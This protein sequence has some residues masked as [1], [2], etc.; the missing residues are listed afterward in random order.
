MTSERLAARHASSAP[1]SRA[2]DRREPN[3]AGSLVAQVAPIDCSH[4]CRRRRSM[5]LHACPA[6][7]RHPARNIEASPATIATIAA[8]EERDAHGSGAHSDQERK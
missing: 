2:L 3:L 8:D 7:L 5:L 4:A 6:R 1:G